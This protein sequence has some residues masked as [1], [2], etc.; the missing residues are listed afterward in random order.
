MSTHEIRLR[1]ILGSVGVHLFLLVILLLWHVDSTIISSPPIQ[2]TLQS[3]TFP[4]SEVRPEPAGG[5]GPR[6][7]GGRTKSRATGKQPATRTTRVNLPERRLAPLDDIVPVPDAHT[8]DAQDRAGQERARVSEGSMA[9]KER[10][11]GTGGK[12]TATDRSGTSRSSSTAGSGSVRESGSA[13][14]GRSSLS[15][16]IQWIGGGK[17]K[18][19]SGS[20]PK[21]PAG[22][23]VEAQIR[24]ELVVAPNGKVRSVRAVQK[25][26]ARLEEAAIREVRKWRFEPL[27]RSVKQ[28]DQKCRVTFNF[29]LK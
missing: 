22:T 2:L 4:V 13:G 23:T 3:F 28:L 7:G 16:D 20:L 27:A 9:R 19:I 8:K 1:A 14:T 17:R 21:Y 24:L 12:E 5:S 18:R 10:Q 6:E 11:A 25:A 26:N 15:G 29:R